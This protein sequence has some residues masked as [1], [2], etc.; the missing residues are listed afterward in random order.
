MVP[1]YF[2]P[3]YTSENTPSVFLSSVLIQTFF[4]QDS[5][6]G[7]VILHLSAIKADAF[8]HSNLVMIKLTQLLELCQVDKAQFWKSFGTD[9]PHTAGAWSWFFSSCLTSSSLSFTVV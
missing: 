7:N 4:C 3:S 9:E 6:N 8:E 5:L 1:H 2:H